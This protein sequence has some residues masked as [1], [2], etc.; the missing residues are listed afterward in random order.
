MQTGQNFW[1]SYWSQET[2]NHQKQQAA[3]PFPIPPFPTAFY[4]VI[5]FS[6]GIATILV[7]GSRTVMLVFTTLNASK[8]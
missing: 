3:A 2:L 7:Q 5:Y 6:F 8:V 1:L 4:M